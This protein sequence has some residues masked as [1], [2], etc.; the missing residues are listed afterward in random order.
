MLLGCGQLTGSWPLPWLGW[1]VQS[2][3]HPSA[4]SVKEQKSGLCPLGGT[5]TQGRDQGN[6]PTLRNPMNGPEGGL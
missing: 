2:H 5:R 1:E 4:S 6:P 3:R